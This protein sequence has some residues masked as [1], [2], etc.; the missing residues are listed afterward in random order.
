M[1]LVGKIILDVLLFPAGSHLPASAIRYSAEA[2]DSA[3]IRYLCVST[4][5]SERGYAA[6]PW[7]ELRNEFISLCHGLGKGAMSQTM[8]VSRRQSH[9][10]ILS[11]G[12]FTA[13]CTQDM[14]LAD[15]DIRRG[16]PLNLGSLNNRAC[17]LFRI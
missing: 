11:R 14:R 13:V 3:K 10:L 1:G 4:M 6:G 17:L 2:E 7:D 5:S 12:D 15:G 8:D 16:V 9:L